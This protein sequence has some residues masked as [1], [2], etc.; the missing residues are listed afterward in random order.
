[1]ADIG[2]P[3]HMFRLTGGGGKGTNHSGLVGEGRQ[4]VFVENFGIQ[5]S[6]CRI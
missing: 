2:I 6:Q 1:M 3:A 4:W 5:N